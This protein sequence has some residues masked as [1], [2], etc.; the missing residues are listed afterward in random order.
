MHKGVEIMQ[1]VF[2]RIVESLVSSVIISLI[3][4][5][6]GTTP[7]SEIAIVNFAISIFSLILLCVIIF[8]QAREHYDA[9]ED[10][11]VYYKS[12][13]MALLVYILIACVFCFFA[14]ISNFLKP[15]YSLVFSPMKAFEYLYSLI[16]T[17][18]LS[19]WLSLLTSSVV[20]I[21]VIL[22]VPLV[23]SPKDFYEE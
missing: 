8:F 5:V 4:V 12:N 3:A 19:C 13:I 16:T 6:A 11:E 23:F 20:I 1:F 10:K 22:T 14:N 7:L 15:Y 18:I 17:D 9:I 2:R 21:I